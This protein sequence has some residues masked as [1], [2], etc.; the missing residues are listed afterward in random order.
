[1]GYDDFVVEIRSATLALNRNGFPA[2]DP[3]TPLHAPWPLASWPSSL[4]ILDN[5]EEYAGQLAGAQFVP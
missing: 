4:T 2:T 5:T 1:M 3:S